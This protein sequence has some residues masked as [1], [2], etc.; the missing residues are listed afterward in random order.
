MQKKGLPKIVPISMIC[1]DFENRIN[2][3][4]DG[5]LNPEERSFCENHID[6]CVYCHNLLKDIESILKV[7]KTLRNSPIPEG[8]RYR[9]RLALRKALELKLE[10]PSNNDK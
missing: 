5:E 9:L 2:D 10:E 4:I 3:F 6:H 1:A 7:A 8:V